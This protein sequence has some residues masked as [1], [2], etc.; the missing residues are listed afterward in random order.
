VKGEIL[1]IDLSKSYDRFTCLYI[2]ILLTHL[3]FKVPFINWIMCCITSVSFAVIINGLAS[4]F[5]HAERGLRKECPLSPLLYLLI[6]EALNR[7]IEEAK[8]RGEFQGIVISPNL[9]INYLLFVD[10]VL[11][12]CN[13][14]R[15]DAQMLSSILNLFGKAIG[16]KINERKSTLSTHNMELEE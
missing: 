16:M 5:F 1:K 8:S 4:Y 15:C 11:I 7:A 12:L 2:Q 3:G 6:V 9:N 13:G 10:D 14:H